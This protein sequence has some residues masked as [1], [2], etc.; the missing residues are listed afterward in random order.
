MVKSIYL[1]QRVS[2]EGVWDAVVWKDHPELFGLFA[3]LPQLTNKEWLSFLVPF[4]A[5]PQITYYI[6]RVYLENIQGYL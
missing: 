5:L 6:L 2:E 1:L 4:L 3:F